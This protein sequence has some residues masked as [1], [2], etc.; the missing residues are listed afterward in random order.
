[1]ML[2]MR[3][4]LDLLRD[5]SRR[6][7]AIAFSA[8]PVGLQI[9]ISSTSSSSIFHSFGSNHFEFIQAVVKAVL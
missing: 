5:I 4:V 9:S 7:V 2:S 1:M 8:L 3:F 6:V